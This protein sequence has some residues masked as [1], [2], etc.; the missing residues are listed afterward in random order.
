MDWKEIAGKITDIAP[1]LGGAVGG[2]VGTAVGL[3][4]SVL[5][6]AFGLKSDAKPEEIAQAISADPEARLKLLIAENE[7]KLKQRDQDIDELKARLG[8]VQSARAREVELVKTTGK[9]ETN[10][11]V[12]AWTV[13]IGFFGLIVAL[14]RTTL[15]PGV[16]EVTFMLF[17][18]LATGFGTVLNYF[19]GSSKGSAEK[20]GLLAKAESIK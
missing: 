13:I 8:D 19:F 2:P 3:A 10:Q 7:F 4:V 1:T 15:P 18:A 5:A 17:G 16:S 20:T 11:Y 9:R 6:K 14:M 12:L